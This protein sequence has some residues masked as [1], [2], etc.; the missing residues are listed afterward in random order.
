[1]AS[2]AYAVFGLMCFAFALIVPMLL[3]AGIIFYLAQ[4]VVR[5]RLLQRDWERLSQGGEDYDTKRRQ[6]GRR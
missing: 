6:Q 5:G 4:R 2:G 1:V 3:L